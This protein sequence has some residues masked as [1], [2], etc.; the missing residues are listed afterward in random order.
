MRAKDRL[1]KPHTSQWQGFKSHRSITNK[2]TEVF[3]DYSHNQILH[4]IQYYGMNPLHLI[5]PSTNTSMHQLCLES[6]STG[7]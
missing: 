3:K 6:M 5:T 1:T 2:L 7:Q 4:T